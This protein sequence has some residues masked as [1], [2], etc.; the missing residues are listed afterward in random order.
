MIILTCANVD[1]APDEFGKWYSGFSFKDVIQKT[2]KMAEQCGY[3]SVVYDLGKLGMGEP[4][5]VEDQTFAQKG[6]YDVKFETG[7]KSRSLFKPEVVFHCLNKHKEFT[8]YL[9]GDAQLI[10]NIDDI[11]TQDYDV[12]VTLRKDSEMEGDW[13]DDHFEIAKFVNAGVVFF[14]PTPA[15]MHFVE[16]WQKKTLELGND[17]KA[18]NKL[19][20][21]DKC[22][23]VNAILNI[24]GVRVKF[25]PCTQYNYYYFEDGL[26]K[27]IRIMHFKGTVRKYYPFDTTKRIYCTTVI[28]V[29]NVARSIK[30]AISKLKKS[31]FLPKKQ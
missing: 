20:C 14:N 6:Y 31:N 9:D 12:G 13:Y 30:K 29:L 10:D 22:P 19:V 21:P 17:Q 18:L 7:Y 27:D 8:A 3:K 15:T 28:P 25:F 24:N 16:E 11:V 1:V 26:E 23:E 5:K 4:F 2:V